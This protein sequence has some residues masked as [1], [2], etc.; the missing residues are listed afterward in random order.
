MSTVG[1][2]VNLIFGFH[3]QANNMWDWMKCDVAYD[4]DVNTV[5]RYYSVSD[6]YSIGP[7]T[8]DIIGVADDALKVDKQ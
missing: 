4:G 6:R 5:A 3:D 8:P 1:T 2:V 7:D